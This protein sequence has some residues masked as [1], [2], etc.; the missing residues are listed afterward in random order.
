MLYRSLK[1]TCWHKIQDLVI[2]LVISN[3]DPS[4]FREASIYAYAI[5]LK[6]NNIHALLK[7]CKFTEL[8]PIDYHPFSLALWD[9]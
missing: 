8:L 5:S 7:N 3:I 1:A 6:M 4:Y 9:L 2:T